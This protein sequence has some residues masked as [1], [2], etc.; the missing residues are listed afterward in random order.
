MMR[1]K[2]LL[3]QIENDREISPETDEE[4]F[5]ALWRSLLLALKEDGF[6]NEAQLRRAEEKIRTQKGNN[7]N[8]PGR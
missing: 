4:F 3:L 5:D 8:H 1:R 6:M 7:L 2:V